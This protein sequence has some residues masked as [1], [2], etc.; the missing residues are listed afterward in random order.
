MDGVQTGFFF[1]TSRLNSYID[2][3]IVRSS[4]KFINLAF[5]WK[6]KQITT[7]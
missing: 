5:V 7:Q 1:P 3:R 6:S 4:S 2:I